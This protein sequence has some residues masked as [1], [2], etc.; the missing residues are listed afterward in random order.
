MKLMVYDR[1][2]HATGLI[3]GVNTPA[4]QFVLINTWDLRH[5]CGWF[6]VLDG[7]GQELAVACTLQEGMSE[8]YRC[9]A[10]ED[11]YSNA[12]I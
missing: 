1:K 11:M 6:K 12:D 2:H 10:T 7:D 8:L 3:A 9:A 4:G 5:D